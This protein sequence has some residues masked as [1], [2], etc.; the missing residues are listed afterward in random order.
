MHD[1]AAVVTSRKPFYRMPVSMPLTE[2][3]ELLRKAFNEGAVVVIDEINSSPMMERL[4]NALLMGTTPEGKRPHHPGF[5]VIGT[6]NPITMAGRRAPSTALS[7]R[8]TTVDLPPYTAEEMQ[9]ILVVKGLARDTATV[10]I[11]AFQAQ[12]T[13]AS[14]HH[15]TPAPTFRDLLRLVNQVLRSEVAIPPIKTAAMIRSECSQSLLEIYFG[16]NPARFGGKFSHYLSERH[17][18]FWFRDLCSYYAAC[19]LGCFGYKTE[20]A[21]RREHIIALH[22]KALQYQ[23]N[24]EQYNELITAIDNGRRLFSPRACQG[25]EAEKSLRH[26]LDEFRRELVSVHESAIPAPSL[27]VC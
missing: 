6:Q 11:N 20:Q 18:I 10:M 19:V 12:R 3:D 8:M 22:E 25:L 27:P 1:M 16:N 14:V 17:N 26:H 13:Y 23:S 21:L 9:A 5:M 2:K 24:P 15:K 4:L 7:R